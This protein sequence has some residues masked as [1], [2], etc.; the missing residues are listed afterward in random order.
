MSSS[1]ALVNATTP[2]PSPSTAD[3]AKPDT[4]KG[5]ENAKD[6]TQAKV[7]L[8]RATFGSGCFWCGE[9][10][11]ERI[12]G[13]KSVVSGYAG[14]NVPYPTYEMVSSGETKRKSN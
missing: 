6:K 13:V 7:K 5:A 2:S 11:F 4:S 14:G 1:R 9:A 8:E 12:P 10:I 3:P